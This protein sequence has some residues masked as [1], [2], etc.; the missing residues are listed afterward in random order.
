[1][2][3]PTGTFAGNDIFRFRVT[4]AAGTSSE[5]SV[6]IAVAGPIGP[7]P[8][9]SVH[10]GDLDATAAASGNRNWKATVT[11]TV[12]NSNHAPVAGAVLS[13]RWGGATGTVKCTTTAAGS[14]TLT[15]SMPNAAASVTFTVTGIVSTL[16]YLASANHDPE[17][18]SNGTTILVSRPA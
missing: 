17:T 4:D 14:C 18:D 16:P 1:M 12:H 8:P 13:G 3:S 10:V 7:P 9:T 15:R 5:A 11:I 2:Y 6:T